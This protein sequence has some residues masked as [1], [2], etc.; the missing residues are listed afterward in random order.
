MNYIPYTHPLYLTQSQVY[1][2]KVG[3]AK[4][5]AGKYTLLA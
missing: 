4:M 1:L 2:L 5:I 3:K